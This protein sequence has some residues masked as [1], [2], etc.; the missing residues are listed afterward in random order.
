MPSL[1]NEYKLFKGIIYSCLKVSSQS[2]YERDRQVDFTSHHADLTTHS[3]YCSQSKHVQKNAIYVCGIHLIAH[4]FSRGCYFHSLNAIRSCA[5]G[6]RVQAPLQTSA[7]HLQF[8]AAKDS[9]QSPA[10]VHS[11]TVSDPA[12][13]DRVH[14]SVRAL[15]ACA[16]SVIVV[17]S[18]KNFHIYNAVL[19]LA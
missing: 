11:D 15:G 6:D 5:H 13:I 2:T 14:R 3:L 4:T 1:K 8:F 9:P 10:D 7:I 19:D 16:S 18:E 17:S 12:Y